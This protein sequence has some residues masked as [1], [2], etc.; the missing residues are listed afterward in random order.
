[1]KTNFV[2]ELPQDRKEKTKK[3]LVWI[4]IFSV[5]MFFAGLTSA[6]IVSMGD[7]FWIKVAFP[8]AFWISTFLILLSSLTLVGAIRFA[9]KGDTKK[10]RLFLIVTTL[11]GA[12]FGVF[13]FQGYQKLV[14]NGAHVVSQIMV[15][16]GRYGDYYEIK[17]DGVILNLEGNQYAKNH[18]ILSDEDNKALRTFA[19]NFTVGTTINDNFNIPNYGKTF[20]LLYKEEPLAL[21]NGKFKKVNGEELLPVEYDRL[22]YLAR[23]IIDGRG[24][25]Y[26]AG[27]LGEDFDLYYK[28][29]ALEY[30]ERKLF[31][32]G[33]ELSANM[34]NKLMR[35][36]SDTSTTYLYLITFLHLLHIVAGVIMLLSYV[37]RSFTEDLTISHAIS[38]RSGAIFWHFLGVLWVYLLLFLLFIH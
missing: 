12:L 33:Q 2:N 10:M 31:Y 37:R 8:N 15:D 27:Q 23:N 25:F 17:M 18:E 32:N 34:Q 3:S 4:L 20:T 21:I 28:G 1:M 11:L 6:Y 5:A 36:N 14:N 9:R 13:Q 30:N 22:T 7:N 35:G 29:K 24:D 26:I 16:D 38:L 19:Q